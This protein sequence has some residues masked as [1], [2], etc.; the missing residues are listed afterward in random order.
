MDKILDPLWK[1]Q[2]TPRG[3]DSLHH[4]DL[5]EEIGETDLLHAAPDVFHHHHYRLVFDKIDLHSHGYQR[6]GRRRVASSF[7]V[8]LERGMESGVVSVNG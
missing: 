2:S 6:V 1:L 4:Y 7:G 8:H 5:A 3:I